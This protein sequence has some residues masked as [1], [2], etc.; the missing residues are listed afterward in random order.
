[1]SSMKVDRLQ[2]RSSC[3]GSIR[4]DVSSI[5]SSGGIGRFG[6]LAIYRLLPSGRCHAFFRLALIN[7][8]CETVNWSRGLFRIWVVATCLWMFGVGFVFYD[9]IVT[10]PVLWG[11]FE[12]YEDAATQPSRSFCIQTTIRN[13]TIRKTRGLLVQYEIEKLRTL[14]E[15]NYL[16]PRRSSNWKAS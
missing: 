2:S 11:G 8:G 14:R 9:R 16:L 7:L 12:F 5:I 1:M 13:H 10:P 4:I 3:A 6:M 15:T